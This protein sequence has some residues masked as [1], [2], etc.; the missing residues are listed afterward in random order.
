MTKTVRHLSTVATIV[1]A[2][3][4]AGC[5]SS[6]LSS[7]GS[8]AGVGKN[9]ISDTDRVFLMAAGSW[10]RNRDSQVTSE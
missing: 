1:V 2:G 10:D 7:I 4:A 3:I 5:S 8:I 9:T 6:P